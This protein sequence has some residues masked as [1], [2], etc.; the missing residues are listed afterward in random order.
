MIKYL[1][2]EVLLF[3]YQQGL[4]PMAESRNA[5]RVQWVEPKKR[6]IFQLGN[7]HISRSLKR[8]ILKKAVSYT[9]LTL[10]TKRIV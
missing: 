7:F 8:V 10:P 6:G 5:K 4:F 2:P 1:S 3:A 9:H